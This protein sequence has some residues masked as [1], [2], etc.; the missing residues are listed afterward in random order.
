MD[1]V[2]ALSVDL[3]CL[4][5]QLE[6]W[7]GPAECRLKWGP[8][9]SFLTSCWEKLQHRGEMCRHTKWTEWPPNASLHFQQ[10]G[11]KSD[12]K[13]AEN[14]EWMLYI[15]NTAVQQF[16]LYWQRG[17]GTNCGDRYH[18]FIS[19][20]LKTKILSLCRLLLN[21]KLFTRKEKPAVTQI[22]FASSFLYD[23]NQ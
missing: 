21:K 4:E 1:G 11:K 23:F 17:K 9:S 3:G 19:L 14:T 8:T 7:Q 20:N 22:I 13:Q 15:T 10:G 5:G 16:Q 12:R 6:Q 2:K 18:E